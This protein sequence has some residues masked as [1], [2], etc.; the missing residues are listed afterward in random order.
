MLLTMPVYL[1]KPC[2][3]IIYGA[4]GNYTAKHAMSH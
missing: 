1:L 4:L 3:G 2:R